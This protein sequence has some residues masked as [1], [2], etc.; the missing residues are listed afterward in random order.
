MNVIRRFKNLITGL[1][2][3]QLTGFVMHVV[4]A[5]R[6]TICLCRTFGAWRR[7]TRPIRGL[8]GLQNRFVRTV[9]TSRIVHVGR[10]VTLR[11][12]VLDLATEAMNVSSSLTWR[13]TV[14]QT[15][16]LMTLLLDRVT[17]AM[18]SCRG[19]LRFRKQMGRIMF[20]T[21]S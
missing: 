5:N 13:F 2:T 16:V 18:L 1:S 12:V 6:L 11:I 7:T 21:G 20:L 9:K 10:A 14:L 4:D 15:R 8:I 19:R 3:R 17:M